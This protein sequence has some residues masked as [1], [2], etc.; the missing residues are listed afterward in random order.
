MILIYSQLP[1]NK[2]EIHKQI[3]LLKDRLFAFFI[4]D[5]FFLFSTESNQKL[6]RELIINHKITL[7]YTNSI[8]QMKF[9][10]T[11]IC[12]LIIFLLKN[13]CSFQSE[14]DNLF[15]K[16]DNIDIVYP[17]IFE[18]FKNKHNK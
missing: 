5:N 6:L 3:D 15:F 2:K 11:E 9:T 1:F 17:T 8:N 4:D 16:E 13:N 7:F 14:L 10:P 12:E 18:I